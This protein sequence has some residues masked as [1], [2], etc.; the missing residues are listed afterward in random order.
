[1]DKKKIA[2][3]IMN[4]AESLESGVLKDNIKIA[5]TNF[6]SELGVENVN[7]AILASKSALFDIVVVGTPLEGFE[8]YE[9]CG[10]DEVAKVLEDLFNKGEIQA[11]VTMHYPFPI[12]VSTVGKIITPAFGKEVFLATTTGTTH[13][14]R[15][16]AMVLNAINGIVVAKAN[17]IENPSLGILNI[18]GAVTVERKLKELK[19]NGFD[20]NF[21]KS[22]RSDGGS[23]LRGN[24]LVAGV[25]DILVCDSLT[26]NVL[27]K[28]FASY[29][30]GG[31]YETTGY[32]YGP[33]VGEGYDKAVFI[34]SRASGAP[35]IKN[36][37]SYAY[38]SVKGDLVKLSKTYYEKAKAAKL[39]EILESLDDKAKEELPQAPMPDKEIVTESI[40]GIDILEIENAVQT[41]WAEKIYA[42]SAM[43]CTGPMVMVSSANIDKAKEILANKGFI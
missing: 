6:G 11:A 9:A 25:P 3:S 30:S 23:L 20:I 16:K 28:T 31:F 37:I 17:G 43:G 22:K 40:G 18:E 36:A 19:E 33:S 26:G 27:V 41:L 32:G 35:V 29:T 39:D 21:A 42:E 38:D 14:K 12:G 5:V 7:E 34:V 10:D 13:A 8:S 1:M 24:D 15:E 2:H 4:L